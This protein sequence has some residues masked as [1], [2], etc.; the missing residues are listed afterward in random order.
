MLV[1][2]RQRTEAVVRPL[3]VV[4]KVAH[5]PCTEFNHA[6]MTPQQGLRVEDLTRAYLGIGRELKELDITKTHDSPTGAFAE[7]LWVLAFGGERA[8]NVAQRD[9]DIAPN[10]GD[11]GRVQVK[12]CVA[13]DE[14]DPPLTPMPK[15]L[16]FDQ[17]AVVVFSD[18]D[19]SVKQAGGVDRAI[20][21][22]LVSKQQGQRV[23]LHAK[24]VLNRSTDVTSDLRAAWKRL[25]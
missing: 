24:R 20:V 12:G 13:Y 9:W 2:P 3:G 15:A 18:D 5:F 11:F 16:D 10:S 1:A 23:R 14:N 7:F 21:A 4:R 17:L 25:G 8:A 19:Y 22:E 6:V